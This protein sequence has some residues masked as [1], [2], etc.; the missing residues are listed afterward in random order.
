M[1]VFN[2]KKFYIILCICLA[3]SFLPVQKAHADTW[4][5][6][7]AAAMLTHTLQQIDRTI[8]GMIM[9]TAK[10]MAAQ[11][12]HQ[13]VGKMILGGD[14][15]ASSGPLYITNWDQYLYTDVAN[16][17]ALVANDFFTIATSGTSS[18]INYVADTAGLNTVGYASYLNQ[19][20]QQSISSTVPKMDILSY[21]SEPSQMFE[22]GNWRG[23]SVFF[24]NVTESPVGWAV[25]YPSVYQGAAAQGRNTAEIQALAYQGFKARKEGDV[26][27]TPGSTIK[28]IQTAAE[29]IGYNIIATAQNIPEIITATVIQTT[30]EIILQGIGNAQSSVQKEVNNAANS[31]RKDVN[32]LIQTGGPGT[33]FQPMY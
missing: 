7:Y 30:S 15:G 4:G 18:A 31:V 2:R 28:D 16:S 19:I 29:N 9:G 8:Q 14:G 22:Q 32:E 27:I 12:V 20:A 33:V 23:P 13:T 26:V 21:V 25:L 6:N 1:S 24:S 3:I 10:Q 11:M 5:A 17:A